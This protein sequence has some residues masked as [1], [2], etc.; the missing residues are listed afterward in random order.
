MARLPITSEVRR[1]MSEQDRRWPVKFGMRAVAI[2]LAFIAMILFAVTTS[3]SK[4]NYGGDDWVDG[5]PLAPVSAKIQILPPFLRP[6][7][8]HETSGS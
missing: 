4:Q 2:P 7:L 3:L 6:F 5:M 1:T 8:R